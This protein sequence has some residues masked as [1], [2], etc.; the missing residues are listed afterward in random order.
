MRINYLILAHKNLNQLKRL[1][2][3]LSKDN[4][5][6]F[7]IFIHLDK[8]WDIPDED[9]KS[10]ETIDYRVKV[11]PERISCRLDDWSLIE[12]ELSLAQNALKNN[13]EDAYFVLLS[14]QDY[15]IKSHSDFLEY[16]KTNYPQPLI[17]VTPWSPYNWVHLKFKNSPIYKKLAH[18][19]IKNR[20]INFIF[21]VFRRGL[22]TLIPH[23]FKMKHRLDKLG[24]DLYG[25]SQWWVLPTKALNEIIQEY[26]HNKN[27]INEYKKTLTPDETFFQTM[28]MRSSLS[29]MVHVNP[30]EQVSQS[31]P[32][33]AYF[34]PSGKKFTGHPHII[35]KGAWN[36]IKN[37]DNYFARKFDENVDAEVFDVID[38]EVF[39]Q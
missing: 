12:A 20:G 2:L 6:D 35:D 18:F 16:C 32:T 1:V 30:P 21:R 22:D 14:G 27:L 4:H 7:S 11:I 39:G 17:D 13:P 38:K 37:Y 36:Q 10:L 23:N 28:T 24:V 3:R 8:K 9:I 5:A 25:G 31:C 15:P 26:N 33:F 19:N 29:H 34:N